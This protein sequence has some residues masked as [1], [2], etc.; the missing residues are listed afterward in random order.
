MKTSDYQKMHILI[1]EVSKHI[2]REDG[3]RAGKAL[4]ALSRYV[5]KCQVKNIKN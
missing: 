4:D 1:K 5:K 3:Y 2:K